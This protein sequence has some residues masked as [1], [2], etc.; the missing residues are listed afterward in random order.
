MLTCSKEYRDIPF[1]HRQHN[2]DGHCAW[3]HGHNWTFRFTFIAKERDKNGFIVDFGKL[4]W[5]KSWIE[6]RFDHA[7]ALNE[8]DPHLDFLRNVLTSPAFGSGDVFAKITEVPDGSCEGL[9]YYLWKS[10]GEL[11]RDRTGGRV[12]VLECTVL[13][14]SKNSATYYGFPWVSQIPEGASTP[15]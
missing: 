1:A 4:G 3:I 8:T 7:L 13:E 5:L 10:V 12:D 11:V 2:H 15:R 6:E 14:D 9:A